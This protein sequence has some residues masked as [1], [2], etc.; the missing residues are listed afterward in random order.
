[1]RSLGLYVDG[2]A[3]WGNPLASRAPGIFVVELPAGA[4]EPPIDYPAVRR[5]AERVPGMTIDGQPTTAPELADRLRTFWLPAEPIVYVGRSAKTLGGRLAAI[6]ATPVGDARPSS[7]AHWLKVLSVQSSLRVW[8]AETDAHEEYEDALLAEV[9]ARNDG[10][11]PF[12]N[13]AS[14]AGERRADGLANS[15]L[16]EAAAATAQRGKATGATPRPRKPAAPRA[17]RTATLK[18]ARA[19]PAAEP[20]YVSA[21]GLEKLTAELEQLRM[22]TRP[23]VITRVATARALGDL[24]E[25]ADY[26]YARKEQSFVEGRIQ[27]LEQMLK[28]SV[29]IEAPA[30][31]DRAHLGSTVVV[32]ADGDEA[33]YLL[34]GPTEADPLAGRISHV[35]PVGRALVGARPG[36]EVTVT[37]PVGTVRYRVREVR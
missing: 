17:P 1:M 32:E 21:E 14:A 23:E 15:L 6:Y 31:G 19:K 8:W 7:A 4:D 26:E 9:A 13:V 34:V 18:G 12:A 30:A 11:L 24:R 2:P 27:A 5:W 3:R 29:V 36:D 37:L 33:T 35:S 28:T 25:N 16:A 10:A 22:V 20:T